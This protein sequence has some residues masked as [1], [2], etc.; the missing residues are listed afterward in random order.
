MQLDV[1][2][3]SRRAIVVGGAAASRRVVA[4]LQA[5]GALV[6]GT[7]EAP[8][9]RHVPLPHH[10]SGW[11]QLL[12]GADLVVIVELSRA[13]EAMLRDA[14]RDLRVWVTRE[15]P[16]A[17]AAIG[18]V[19]LVGAGPGDEGLLTLAGRD[20]LA[21]ADIVFFDRLAPLAALE[22]WAAGAELVDVGKTPGHHAV[23][24]REIEQ[25]MVAAALQGRTVVRFKGGDPFVFGRGGEEV[26]ACREAGVP[27]TVVSGVT[28]AIAVPA[29]AGVPVTHREV[30][31]SFTVISGH[32]PLDDDTVRHL[33]GLGGTLVVLMGVNTLPHLAASLRRHGAAADLP[34]A[35]IESGL[36]TRQR[37][38]IT[39]LDEATSVAAR[40][41]VRSPAV[42]VFG[43]VVRVSPADALDDVVALA[44]GR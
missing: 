38:T 25:M 31:R 26:A 32:A 28:S 42:L 24:Q 21:A 7:H 16:A 17:T 11:T 27:V 23:P 5:A 43:E 33:A 4:R 3:T 39:T 29:A 19:T 12:S 20:A 6:F 41:R 34:V 1:D 37:T 13:G 36:T 2:L 44:T 18:R 10:R 8:G 14:V 40:L 9:V 35:I 22:R 30:S 15:A